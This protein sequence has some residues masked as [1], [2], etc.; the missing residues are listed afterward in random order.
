MLRPIKLKLAVYEAEA[1][2][3]Y[4]QRLFEICVTA[5]PGQ[6]VRPEVVTIAEHFQKFDTAVR[7]KL[8]RSANQLGTYSI[9]Q[10][11]SIF[12]WYR[13]QQENNGPVI[14]SILGKLDYELKNSNRVPE[15]AF[16]KT[17]YDH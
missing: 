11:V 3:K 5:Q 12:L 17:L 16:P 13:W 2:R 4:L 7:S 10:S 6:I 14:Q 15:T 9:P 1:L 8:F